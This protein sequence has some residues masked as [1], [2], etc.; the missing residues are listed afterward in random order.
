MITR[1]LKCDL[2]EQEVRERADKLAMLVG[3]KDSL[4]DSRKVDSKRRKE[5]DQLGATMCR[6]GIEISTR[7]EFRNVECVEE[8]D[9]DDK[10]VSLVRK[11]TGEVVES[12]KMRPDEL[13]GELV[14]LQAAS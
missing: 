14:A 9:W 11:D 12:R 5:I 4:E 6:L 8:R 3:E 10:T 13:Q 7:S 2:S 1:K